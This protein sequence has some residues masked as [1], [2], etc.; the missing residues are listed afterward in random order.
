M[1]SED[2]LA[3]V[4][5]LQVNPR[6]AWREVGDAVGLSAE[7]SARRWEALREAGLAWIT[8]APGPRY[9]AGGASAFVFAS[10][11]SSH[12][13]LL[14]RLVA[15]PA[16][17]TVSIV[18]GSSDV[19]ADCFAPDRNA[20]AESLITT[21]RD[22]PGIGA[23]D[24]FLVTKLYR[25][26]VEWREDALDPGQVR[27]LTPGQG[28]GTA[29]WPDAVDAAIVRALAADGRAAWAEIADALRISPQTV[30][31]RT[32]RLIDSGLLAFRCDVS[33]PD[34]H[35]G[36]QEATLVLDVPPSQLDAVA[37]HCAALPEC[38]VSAQVF[39]RGNLLI[40]L[41]LRELLR[42]HT[43]EEAIERSAP[44]TRIVSRHTVLRSV[45]RMGRLLSSH[46]RAT[47]FVALP[48]WSGNDI[49]RIPGAAR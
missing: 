39:G 28:A 19:L 46:G 13:R 36:Q 6:A 1:I 12:D 34:A 25:Q 4:H 32:D 35:P 10:V 29:Y 44:G 49:P 20:L 23:H 3:I 45:K 22:L 42:I 14:E 38:R 48:F 47:G 27:S 15:N 24:V 16:C 5:A 7:T 2:D 26:S 33:D 17:G 31:R 18:A 8:P 37:R 40:T 41:R 11:T 30:R 9:L 21:F 43:L